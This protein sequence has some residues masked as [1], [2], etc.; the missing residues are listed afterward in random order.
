MLATLAIAILALYL[1][2]AE[3]LLGRHAHRQ[4]LAALDADAPGAR[5]HTRGRRCA[6]ARCPDRQ[7][8]NP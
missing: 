2:I 6:G 4:L 3:P 1:L 7:T 8:G 5:R